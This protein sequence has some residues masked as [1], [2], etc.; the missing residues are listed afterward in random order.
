MPVAR[1]DTIRRQRNPELRRAVERAVLDFADHQT[2]YEAIARE[3]LR[4]HEHRGRVL[5]VR[6][7]NDERRKSTSESGTNP[8]LGATSRRPD[9]T[10]RF[11]WKNA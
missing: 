3:Y 2:P 8:R 5:V 1:L 9:T 11:Q 10:L 7:T 4:S 6:P